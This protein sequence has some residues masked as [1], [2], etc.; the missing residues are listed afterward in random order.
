MKLID[1]F[2][3]FALKGN[4]ID[5]A[6]GVVIGG[7]FGKIVASFVNDVL[8][9]VLGL[10]LGKVNFSDLKIVIEPAAG[11][12]PELAIRYGAFL[13][14]VMDFVIIAFCIF[15]AIRFINRFTQKQ[16]AVEEAKAPEPDK[17]EVLLMEIRDI[18]KNNQR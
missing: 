16:K 3:A 2:K 5:L 17:Q 18:L 15:I 7:A 11:D 10:I 8:M 14:S 1:E 13:Q 4:V 12:V 6:V 9:P